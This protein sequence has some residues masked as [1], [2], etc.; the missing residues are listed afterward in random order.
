MYIYDSFLL[1]S[2]KEFGMWLRIDLCFG[3]RA[4]NARQTYSFGDRLDFCRL[5]ASF[6]SSLEST[7][8]LCKQGT[9]N[10]RTITMNV[11]QRL[12]TK[13]FGEKN[14]V[15]P[16]LIKKLMIK[17]VFKRKISIFCWP[18]QENLVEKIRNRCKFEIEL[19]L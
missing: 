3:Q 10:R 14:C 17:A 19:L 13:K 2:L 9:Y 12:E 15:N 11:G 5:S 7:I 1:L 4:S 8:S 16:M 18:W 6:I